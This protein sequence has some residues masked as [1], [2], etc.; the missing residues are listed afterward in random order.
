MHL[1]D[2]WV[3]KHFSSRFDDKENGDIAK[4]FQQ[5][6]KKKS[7]KMDA[8][9]DLSVLN[10]AMDVDVHK[11]L[12]NHC[13]LV[14]AIVN[15]YYYVDI[16][17]LDLLSYGNIGL[18]FAVHKFDPSKGSS[19]KRYAAYCIIRSINQFLENEGCMVRI[20]HH[21]HTQLRNFNR[22]AKDFFAVYGTSPTIVNMFSM[23][24]M[25][26]KQLLVIID[27]M[28]LK[29]GIA[30][31]DVPVNEEQNM[32][33]E[34]LLPADSCEMPDCAYESK[35]FFAE[36]N[37][38]LSK[39]SERERFILIHRFGLNGS[40]K[41]TLQSIAQKYNLSTERIRQIQKS[42]ISKL[43]KIMQETQN[44]DYF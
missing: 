3:E 11:L 2:Y 13:Y 31:L 19:F 23:L 42:A 5:Y 12:L 18:L 30:S 37:S 43:K 20:P 21:M 36:F 33:L 10:K 7:R 27:A 6:M 22:V 1:G 35:N 26:K 15:R 25:K 29:H 28:N 17:L 39:I 24:A 34:D 9:S 14:R 16:E 4:K 32:V 40:E 8:F 38:F 44:N 41:L